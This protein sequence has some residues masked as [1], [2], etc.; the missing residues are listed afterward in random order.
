MLTKDQ[1]LTVAEAIYKAEVERELCLP[2]SKM[3][4]E[5]DVT[6]SYRIA[7]I[8]TELKIAA[9]R[10]VRGKKIGLTSKAMQRLVKV[11]EPDY[12]NLFDNWF[13]DSSSALKRDDLNHPTVEI[14]LAFVLKKDLS[15]PDVNAADVIQAT[16]FIMPAFEIVDTRYKE[17]GDSIIVD[18]VAD[19]ASCGGIIL[20]GKPSRLK[21]IDLSR[22]G[23]A[24]LKNGIIE[25]TG[26]AAAVM[27]NPINSV[28]WLARKLHEFGDG[29]NAGDTIL[30]GSFVQ[31]IPFDRG[32]TIT[33]NFGEL[34]VLSFGVV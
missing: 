27:G 32:D 33:A 30:S 16:D 28:S 14:E 19:A 12:G 3:F 21:G 10:K 6:D 1:Q 17:R 23:A 22:Q 24:L 5:A 13:L 25:Q 11:D 31:M 29:L 26:T 34:G 20:G 4:P 15:G 18:S 9:G 2:P 7:Q 8:V